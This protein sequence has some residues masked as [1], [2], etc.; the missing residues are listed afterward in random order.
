MQNLKLINN[1]CF[2]SLLVFMNS[3]LPVR[4]M[5]MDGTYECRLGWTWLTTSVVVVGYS[6]TYKEGHASFEYAEV[7]GKRYNKI[8]QRSFG[9]PGDTPHI[10]I[11]KQKDKRV[12]LEFHQSSSYWGY[13]SEGVAVVIETKSFSEKDGSKWERDRRYCEKQ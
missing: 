11:E 9:L 5:S 3:A 1:L 2:L 7:N 13:A 10:V 4:A 8:Y 6:Q 12:K